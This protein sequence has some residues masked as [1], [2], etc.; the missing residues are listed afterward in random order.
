M[1]GSRTWLLLCA[2][3]GVASVLLWWARASAQDAL[4]WHADTWTSHPWT[5]WTSAW[6]HRNTP[7]LIVNQVA[8]GV[9]TGLAW[10]LRPTRTATLAWVLAWPLSQLSLLLWPQISHA[11]GLSGVLHAGATVMAVELILRRVQVDKARRWGL[12]LAAGLA[13]K[14][15]MARA[16]HRPVVW[17]NGSEMSVVLA[18]DLTGVFWGLALATGAIGLGRLWR[19]WRRPALAAGR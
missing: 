12:M 2:M 4:T 9:L 18:A 15:A 5:L 7:H 17:D 16:W 19:Y 8:L 1:R 13:V 11:T 3:H 10:V 14:L 6:V